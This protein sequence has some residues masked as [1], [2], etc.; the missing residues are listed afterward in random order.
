MGEWEA[1]RRDEGASDTSVSIPFCIS[2][3]L[4]TVVRFHKPQKQIVNTKQDVGG[5]QNEISYKQ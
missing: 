3:T 4:R 2:L 1:G 5:T